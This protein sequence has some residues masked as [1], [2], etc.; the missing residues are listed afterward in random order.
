MWKIELLLLCKL[1]LNQPAFILGVDWERE[2]GNSPLLSIDSVLAPSLCLSGILMLYLCPCIW[3]ARVPKSDSGLCNTIV[4]ITAD[5]KCVPWSV[6]TSSVVE[7]VLENYPSL[8]QLKSDQLITSKLLEND[9]DKPHNLK[10]QWKKNHPFLSSFSMSLEFWVWNVWFKNILIKPS[11]KKNVQAKFWFS[12]I[13]YR[14]VFVQSLQGFL[15]F[16]R[17]REKKVTL[18]SLFPKLKHGLVDEQDSW[19]RKLFL[20]KRAEKENMPLRQIE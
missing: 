18:K 19:T 20:E 3:H 2:K 7:G 16:L 1:G 14:G 13:V 12:T 11:L 4:K 10:I 6:A 17:K 8:Q 15:I 9:P 5:D